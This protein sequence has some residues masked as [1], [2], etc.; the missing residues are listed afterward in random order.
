MIV[1]PLPSSSRKAN[2]AGTP[3][4][5]G[6]PVNLNTANDEVGAIGFCVGRREGD[7]RV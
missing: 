4:H 2:I 3:G 7:R 6:S 5:R 1:S